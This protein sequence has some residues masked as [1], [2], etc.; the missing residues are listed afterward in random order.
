MKEEASRERT[1]IDRVGEAFELH[2]LFVKLSH[3]ID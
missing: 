3:E 1:C 2:A